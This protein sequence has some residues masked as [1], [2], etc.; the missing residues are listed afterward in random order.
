MKEEIKRMDQAVASSSKFIKE[1]KRADTQYI[2]MGQAISD[3]W[4]TS[5]V[6]QDP[7]ALKIPSYPSLESLNEE[8][9]E[10]LTEAQYGYYSLKREII[11]EKL[12]W[13][14]GIYCTHL[15]EYEE[16]DPKKRSQKY[17]LQY[18][19]ISNRLHGQFEVIASMLA[20]P[21]EESLFTYPPLD[22]I[23]EMVE[24]QDLSEEGRNFFQQLMREIEIK[25]AIAE[26]VFHNRYTIVVNSSEMVEGDKQH[27][28]YQKESKKLIDFCRKMIDKKDKEAGYIDR[29]Q[30][31]GVPDVK[32]IS[33]KELNEKKQRP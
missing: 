14:Y 19:D 29:E 11:M 8:P 27:K 15:K 32:P 33:K 7:N 21:F 9:K 18:N 22:Y 30:P 24:Q 5:D 10:E 1:L 31:Q 13:A 17:L 28:D 16:A 23:M 3:F 20:L 12:A 25:N 4:D 6:T 26:K 2:A